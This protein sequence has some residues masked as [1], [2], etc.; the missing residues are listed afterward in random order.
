MNPPILGRLT[1]A[2]YLLFGG[3]SMNT[4]LDRTHKNAPRWGVTLLRAL[5]DDEQWDTRLGAR[6]TQR[7]I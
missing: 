4:Q 5:H 3:G 1:R 6:F 7:F 2:C